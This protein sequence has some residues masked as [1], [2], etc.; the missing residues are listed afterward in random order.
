MSAEMLQLIAAMIATNLA[1][2][3]DDD[4]EALLIDLFDRP[5]RRI[6]LPEG[7]GS[8]HE[9]GREEQEHQ[10]RIFFDPSDDSNA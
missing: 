4:A 9:E 3:G 2:A 1:K 10:E 8:Y 7:G 6:E 5:S